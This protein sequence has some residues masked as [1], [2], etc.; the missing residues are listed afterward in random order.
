MKRGI[1]WIAKWLHTKIPTMPIALANNDYLEL[2]IFTTLPRQSVNN[3]SI[4][5]IMVLMHNAEHLLVKRAFSVEASKRQLPLVLLMCSFIFSSMSVN[6]FCACI[7]ASL[8]TTRS[9]A[10]IRGSRSYLASSN[11]FLADFAR[12]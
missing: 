7:I 1:P 11:S 9:L 12:T 5:F 6:L 3:T 8:P 4:I 2:R 10:I